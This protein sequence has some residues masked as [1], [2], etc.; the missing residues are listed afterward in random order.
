M[1]ILRVAWLVLLLPL[2]F[3]LGEIDSHGHSINYQVEET[4][5]CRSCW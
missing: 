5:Q 4:E 2:D 3:F 1:K